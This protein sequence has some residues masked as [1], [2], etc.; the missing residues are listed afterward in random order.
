MFQVAKQLHDVNLMCTDP[1]TD[2]KIMVWFLQSNWIAFQPEGF[3]TRGI[4]NMMK[5]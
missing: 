2:T 4:M 5:A 1:L 3:I